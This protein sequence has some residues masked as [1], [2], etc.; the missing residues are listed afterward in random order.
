MEDS[1]QPVKSFL[2]MASPGDLAGSQHRNARRGCAGLACMDDEAG[3]SAC[4]P[5]A[6]HTR[7][8][9]RAD[10][11]D[12]TPASSSSMQLRAALLASGRAR[13]RPRAAADQSSYLTLCASSATGC[14][15]ALRLLPPECR[16]S[17]LR[18][19]G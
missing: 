17:E 6:S 13:S 4:T 18:M 8:P 9:R 11:P 19:Q 14:R 10:A 5:C 7:S 12:E 15:T 3:L 16:A 1:P 2:K